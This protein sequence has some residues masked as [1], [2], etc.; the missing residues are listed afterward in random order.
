MY[1]GVLRFL[2]LR[3]AFSAARENIGGFRFSFPA[4]NSSSVCSSTAGV[5]FPLNPESFMFSEMNCNTSST[6]GGSLGLRFMCH[7]QNARQ[8]AVKS[9]TDYCPHHAGIIFHTFLFS[10]SFRSQLMLRVDFSSWAIC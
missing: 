9:R 10:P 5:I 7:S 8:T 4:R 1:H 2:V 3:M 6:S